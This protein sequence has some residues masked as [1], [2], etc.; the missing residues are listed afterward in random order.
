[1]IMGHKMGVKKV[2]KKYK[3]YKL[4]RIILWAAIGLFFVYQP[5]IKFKLVT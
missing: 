5:L 1:M 4:F 3:N 2:G